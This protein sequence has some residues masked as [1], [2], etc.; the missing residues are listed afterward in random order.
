MNLI[1]E[2]T[3]RITNNETVGREYTFD[4]HSFILLLLM[5]KNVLNPY[6]RHCLILIDL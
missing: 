1:K 2:T 4:Y 3:Q 6:F 5:G